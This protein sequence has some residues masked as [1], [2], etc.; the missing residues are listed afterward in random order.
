MYINCRKWCWYW[1]WIR[2]DGRWPVE[3]WQNLHENVHFDLSG[4]PEWMA[5]LSP[6]LCSI[7]N[8]LFDYYFDFIVSLTV[9]ID[10]LMQGRKWTFGMRSTGS[11]CGVTL[12]VAHHRFLFFM[13]FIW[14]CDEIGKLHCKPWWATKKQQQLPFVTQSSAHWARAGRRFGWKVLFCGSYDAINN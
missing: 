2:F 3:Q 11:G 9:V 12:I 10:Q 5:L 13:L 1:I 4:W 7:H 8:I 14:R 6:V